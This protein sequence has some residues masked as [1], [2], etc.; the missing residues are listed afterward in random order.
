MNMIQSRGMNQ[1]LW[2]MFSTLSVVL[3]GS[4]TGLSRQKTFPFNLLLLSSIICGTTPSCSYG[5]VPLILV[6]MWLS[7]D[8]ECIYRGDIIILIWF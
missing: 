8:T 2:Y 6:I 5:N 4:L 3:V 1:L 7:R